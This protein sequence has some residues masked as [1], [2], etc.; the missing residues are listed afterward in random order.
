MHVIQAGI[1][2][3]KLLWISLMI[4]ISLLPFFTTY[5]FKMETYCLYVLCSTVL[6]LIMVF[7]K[8]YLREKGILIPIVLWLLVV[9]VTSYYSIYRYAA[10]DNA[11][12]MLF[13]ILIFIVLSGLDHKRKMQIALVL[14]GASFFISMGA[15]FQYVLFVRE[16]IPFS[17]IQNHL[18]TDKKFFTQ[19]VFAQRHRA[20]FIFANPNLLASYLVMINLVIVS[21]WLVQKKRLLSYI[22]LLLL[23]MNCYVLWL[24]RSL[25]GLASFIFGLFVFLTLLSSGTIKNKSRFNRLLILL[26]G[27]LFVLFILIF[28][29]RL[30]YNSGIDSLFLSLRGRLEFWGASLRII[31]DRPLRF[32]GLG[33]FRYL[34]SL[35]AP[36]AA[37]ESTM[38]HNI[39]LQLWI[40]TGLCGLLV[41]IWFLSALIY[42]GLKNLSEMQSCFKLRVFHSAVLSAV[43][44]FLFH[45]M[46]DLSFFVSQTAIIWWILCAL[47]VCDRRNLIDK[48]ADH[49]MNKKM[50]SE[51]E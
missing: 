14:I 5:L 47:I 3:K 8:V 1:M 39:F 38:A 12:G 4:C 30:A 44:A 19:Q 28:V 10:F 48:Y 15:M 26:S 7:E 23:I 41:F 33:G 29:R 50:K 20:V 9:V 21:F 34:Y 35:Y 49:G 36:S 16:I 25:T 46:L 11:R 24:T 22:Y 37:F 27:G 2:L 43:L 31:A 45:N 42:K 51:E 40:E 13:C 32:A 6:L 17:D 18:L